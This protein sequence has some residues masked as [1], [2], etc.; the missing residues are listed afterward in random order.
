MALKMGVEMGTEIGIA[1]QGLGPMAD[2]TGHCAVWGKGGF[3]TIAAMIW[4]PIGAFWGKNLQG[5]AQK[6]SWSILA[7]Q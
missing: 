1:A 7:I 2:I 6:G 3:Q 4:P 5:R